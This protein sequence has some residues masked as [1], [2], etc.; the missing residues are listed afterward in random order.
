MSGFDLNRILGVTMDTEKWISTIHNYVPISSVGELIVHTKY[1]DRLKIVAFQ[2]ANLK[3]EVWSIIVNDCL[4]YI[5][6]AH[7]ISQPSTWNI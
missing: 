4:Q 7:N 5:E 3:R 2:N 6:R 1:I